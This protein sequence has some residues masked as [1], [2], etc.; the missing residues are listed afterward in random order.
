MSRDEADAF[1]RELGEVPERSSSVRPVA[2]VDRI[3]A[4]GEGHEV[5]VGTLRADPE[6]EW[7]GD[8]WPGEPH[9]LNPPRSAVEAA[10]RREAQAAFWRAMMRAP[11]A[12]GYRRKRRPL[13]TDDFI[14]SGRAVGT[15]LTC[16]TC[17]NEFVRRGARG[18]VPTLCDGCAAASRNRPGK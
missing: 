3:V 11:Y 5:R 7:I 6:T 14:R 9:W 8:H 15:P 4:D 16:A 1:L 18:P 12:T 17:G 13:R 10:A 2:T